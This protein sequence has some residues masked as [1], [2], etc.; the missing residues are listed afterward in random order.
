MRLYEGKEGWLTVSKNTLESGAKEV[1]FITSV[2]D[3]YRFAD[4][5]EYDEGYYIPARIQKGIIFRQLLL[6]SPQAIEQQKR[7]AQ[8]LRKTRFLSE[9][10]EFRGA[11][12][13]YGNDVAYMTG[14]EPLVGVIITSPLIA[15]MEQKLFEEL[16]QHTESKET[17]TRSMTG[18]RS[19][20][21]PG[22]ART[23]KD[24]F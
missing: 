23:K 7:D 13:I 2:E 10:T 5:K 6:R 15:E 21:S 3:I 12:F 20:V 11:K 18:G 16:W 4:Q 1:L 22:S 9:K 14:D 8:E 17:H 24:T 19:L